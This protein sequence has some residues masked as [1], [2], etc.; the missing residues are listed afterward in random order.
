MKKAYLPK[1]CKDQG[2][3]E[4]EKCDI[5]FK[6]K[7]MPK[8]CREAGVSS[9][10]ECDQ[11]MFKKYAPGECLEAGIEEESAC[12][13]FMFNK[14]APLVKC[15]GLEEWQCK[16]LVKERHIGNIAATQN[17]FKKIKEET[18]ELI[19]ETIKVEELES[20]IVQEKD[21]IPVGKKDTFLKIIAADEKLMLNENND[22]IQTSP[23]ALMIDSDEDS[24]SDDTE[25]R[26]GT[27]PF[28]GDTDGDGYSDSE[29]IKNGY[30]PLGEGDLKKEMAPVDQAL[31]E[32]KVFGHPK[33]EGEEIENLVVESIENALDEQN[34]QNAGYLLGG[35]SEPNSVV[36]IY[37]YSP[38]PLIVTVQTD[39]YGNWKYEL[40]QSLK[41][42]EHEVYAVINDNTGKVI[43]KSKPLNFFVKEAK[44]ISVKDFVTLEAKASSQTEKESEISL[45]NY[46]IAALLIT[47]A[48]ILIFALII[49]RKRKIGDKKIEA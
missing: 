7:Y 8:E 32:N 1:E 33:S 45:R 22:L 9:K 10:K 40:S 27:D 23:I 37:V 47:T 18:K 21:I 11:I 36:T 26:I 16:N 42:G 3:E 24:L 30:N 2:I 25:K 31:L 13:K 5:Y 34:N 4:E 15:E 29:E 49:I 38:L 39:E 14:Y 46:L 44:A 19:N 20:K 48:G 41:E 6:Q 35:K 43:S 12:Q 17:K 28:N